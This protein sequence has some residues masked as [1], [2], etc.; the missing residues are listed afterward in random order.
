MNITKEVASNIVKNIVDDSTSEVEVNG[1]TVRV[2]AIV[3]KPVAQTIVTNVLDGCFGDDGEYDPITKEFLKKLLILTAYTDIE[4]PDGVSEKY[5]FI[6]GTGIFD[7]ITPSIDS[8]Q[9][10]EIFDAIDE[11]VKQIQQMNANTIG[12]SLIQLYA[13]VSAITAEFSKLYGN[14]SADQMAAF[15][16]AV[17]DSKLDEK[18]LVDAITSTKE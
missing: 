16:S 2:R 17:S 14:V 12:K 5:A 18:K 8:V 7:C 3:D 1:Y 10:A 9:L 13:D 15:V 11:G 6:Y 4:L